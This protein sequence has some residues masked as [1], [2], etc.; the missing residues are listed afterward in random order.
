[1]PQPKKA[2]SLNAVRD[3]LDHIR[4]REMY[5]NPL[6]LLR[7]K[8][9]FMFL[10]F[11]YD[12]IDIDDPYTLPSPRLGRSWVLSRYTTEEEIVSTA[13]RAVEEVTLARLRDRFVYKGKSVYNFPLNTSS[14]D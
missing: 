4:I 5:R 13:Y 8:E 6:F 11:G 12:D 1:M 2:Y 3:V 9:E 10:R 14:N 7:E